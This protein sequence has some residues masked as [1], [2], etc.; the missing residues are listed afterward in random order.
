MARIEIIDATGRPHGIDT[1]DTEILSKW[2]ME[3]MAVINPNSVFPV[4]IRIFPE[5]MDGKSDFPFKSPFEQNQFQSA[6][7][8][9]IDINDLVD[10]LKNH[11]YNEEQVNDCNS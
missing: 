6:W 9:I 2:M 10:R 5:F 3:R 1:Q 7:F 4:Q 11:M 8:G